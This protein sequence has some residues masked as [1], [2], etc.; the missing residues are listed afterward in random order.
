MLQAIVGRAG[1]GVRVLLVC[2][3]AV[4]PVWLAC[5]L[6]P[7]RAVA[8]EGLSPWFHLTSA[9]RPGNLPRG[10]EQNEVQE[11]SAAPETVFV[12]KVEA[13]EEKTTVGAFETE[14]Y[15]FGFAERL[16]AANVEVALDGIYGAG[17]VRVSGQGAEG[18]PPLRVESVGEDAD[19]SVPVI[20]I[21]EVV[22]G[23]AS[24]HVVSGARP[25]GELVVT[26]VNV[27]EAA[28]DGETEPV[29]LSDTLPSHLRALFIEGNTRSRGGAELG[30]VSCDLEQLSCTFKEGCVPVTPSCGQAKGVLSPFD[31]VEVVIGVEVEE[32]ARTGEQNQARV[33]G[34]G[35]P[36]VETEH[37]ITVSNAPTPFGVETYE[38]TPENAGGTVDAQAGSHPFQFT[39]TFNLNQAT[40]VSPETKELRPVPAGLA[41]NVVVKLPPGLIGNPTVYPRCSLALFAKENCPDASAVGVAVATYHEPVSAGVLGLLT[42]Q[43]PIFNLEPAA[44]EPARFGF[45]PANVPVFLNASVRTGEDYGVTVS[46][47]DVPQT[48]GFISN[49]VTIWGV[50]GEAAHN[51]TRGTGCLELSQGLTEPAHPCESLSESAPPPFLT[52]PTSCTGEPL[53]TEAKVDS[54][55][56]PVFVSSTPDP[57]NPLPT[58]DGCG[59]LPFSSEI[60]VSPDKQSASSASGLKTDVHVAQE[61]NLNATG[62]AEAAVKNITVTL[63]EGLSVNPASADGLQACTLAQIGLESAI[64]PTCPDASKIANVTV[65]TPLLSTP[66]HGAVYLAA[67]QNFKAGPLENPFGSLVAIYLVARDPVSGVLVKLSGQVTLSPSG[68][69]TTRFANNPQLPFEDAEIE[70]FEGARAPLATP[71]L[72]RRPGEE[73]YV[74]H[75]TFEPWSNTS[76]HQQALASSSSFFI[77][78]GPGG[79]PCPNPPGVQSSTTLPFT[80]TLTAESTSVDAGLFTPLATTISREDGQ[81]GVQAATVHYPN[82]LAG[83]LP[84]VALCPEAQAN[85][86]TCGPESQIGE[87]TAS[88][89]VGTDPF[90][91]TGGKV[92]LTEKYEGAPFGVSIV[93]PAAA[94]PFDLQEGHPVVVRGKVEVDPR[95]SALSVTTNSTEPYAIP[96]I[97]EGFP[98]ALRHVNVTVTRPHFAFN[99]ANCEPLAITGTITSPEGASAAVSTPFHVTNCASLK[100]PPKLTVSTAGLGSKTNGTS[101]L[102]KIAYPSNAM[103]SDAWFKE[104]KLDF[105]K[106]LPARLSTI[107]QACT[108]QTFTADHA[109]CPAASII[110]HAI[111]HTPVLPVPL[112]GNVY[113]VSYANQKFPEAV[114]VLSGY[115][116]TVEMHTETFIDKQTGVTSATLRTIPEL[117][118][119]SIEV[120]IPDGKFSEFGVNL[121]HDNF[122]LCGHS[123]Q[124][125]IH[126]VASNGL[127]IR[128][129]TPIAVTGCPKATKHKVKH[130]RHR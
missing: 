62:L 82:G 58:L 95:T 31:Q 84:N 19:R 122:D 73:G 52:L 48:I 99:P 30:N 93:T 127:E 46:V 69:I 10:L 118:F 41:K 2:A 89:G 111:V 102:L 6:V 125:P 57:T 32:G 33:S 96:Q 47:D 72:C 1:S 54:W 78:S 11:I 43:T 108:Q 35:A 67:P 65:H 110:G 90:T 76:E 74:T 44:G 86:G 70:F 36:P 9:S 50:P 37:P 121:P 12:L 16:T 27:G 120:S 79:A 18:L 61:E 42:I 106:Q 53:K 103:G 63:P 7:S 24:A 55:A 94:G 85:A 98:L 123:L 126:F 66:L 71:A 83:L 112:T 40:T 77:T 39:T 101:L 128:E 109:A 22:F 75:A 49:T 26:A 107:Q 21:G 117:P 45:A 104:A 119:E 100:F 34:G 25:D 56:D 13:H 88:V 3:V 64:E 4:A 97:I 14:P 105:P 17:N 129:N 8:A 87:D 80:P 5:A 114:L 68:Q 15:E 92:Y 113:F 115:G 60:R 130:K 28:A 20:Q 38:M 29:E 59:L 51:A 116:V 124:M 91:V 23:S 81:Q